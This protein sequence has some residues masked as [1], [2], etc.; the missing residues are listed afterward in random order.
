MGDSWGQHFWL[1]R[2]GEATYLTKYWPS[3]GGA[4]GKSAGTELAVLVV[5]VR[6]KQA[7]F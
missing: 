4:A 2:P 7:E 1:C 5:G 3:L 6:G